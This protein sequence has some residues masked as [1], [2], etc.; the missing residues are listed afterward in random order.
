MNMEIWPFTNWGSQREMPSECSINPA[1][2]YPAEEEPSFDYERLL[3]EGAS[4][5]TLEAGR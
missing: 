1:M 4:L 5:N 2:P 3:E